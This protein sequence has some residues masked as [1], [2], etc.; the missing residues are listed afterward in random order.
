VLFTDLADDGFPEAM[1]ACIWLFMRPCGC[2]VATLSTDAAAT[3][4]RAR[5]RM[6][7]FA[8]EHEAAWYEHTQVLL[9]PKASVESDR[10]LWPVGC[11]HVLAVVA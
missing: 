8:F 1:A 9:A 4:E 2:I 7:E 6:T 10:T 11:T 5:Q 3:P